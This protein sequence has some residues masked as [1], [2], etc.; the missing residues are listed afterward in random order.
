MLVALSWAM[1]RTY[2]KDIEGGGERWWAK[3]KETDK[4]K[5]LY[6]P[7]PHFPVLSPQEKKIKAKNPKHDCLRPHGR[8]MISKQH[9]Q[10]DDEL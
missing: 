4:C 10:K 2:N 5:A 8:R 3:H 7:P 9:C 6:F 1:V